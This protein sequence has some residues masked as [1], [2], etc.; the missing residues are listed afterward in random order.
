MTTG[1]ITD[2]SSWINARE[3]IFFDS[4]VHIKHKIE[5][6]DVEYFE[7]YNQLSALQKYLEDN[8]ALP[9]DRNVQLPLDEYYEEIEDRINEILHDM[10]K[11]DVLLYKS[12]KDKIDLY[13]KQ[14]KE[15]INKHILILHRKRKQKIIYDD[16]GTENIEAWEKE[17]NYFLNTTFYDKPNL[18]DLHQTFSIIT[19][20]Q[21][22]HDMIDNIL[23]EYKEKEILNDN[24]FDEKM[25]GYDYEIYCEKILKTNG[26]RARKTKDSGD[27]G[28]DIIA[29]K[30]DLRVVIQCKK[31]SYNVG[32][33]AVQEVFSAK[34]FYDGNKAI[35][36]SSRG[37]YTKSAKE[38]G[39]KLNV[40]LLHHED[41]INLEKLLKS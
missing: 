7:C 6:E 10:I 29:E 21:E 26:W 30:N 32:N 13:F 33:K 25:S 1:E 38:L 12:S 2:D 34:E 5:I 9:A 15:L 3:A 35:V 39:K 37:G 36:I 14:L 40:S 24:T 4:F 11:N 17:K 23:D 28:A 8:R 22:T 27:Q 41:L 31:Y 20:M 19:I 18:Y 16:Y